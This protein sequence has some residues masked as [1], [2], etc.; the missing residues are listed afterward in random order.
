M[1]RQFEYVVGGRF[2]Q[3][4]SGKYSNILQFSINGTKSYPEHQFSLT[5]HSGPNPSNLS[6]IAHPPPDHPLNLNQIFL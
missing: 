2:F 5:Q 4:L 3:K 1:S 6:D